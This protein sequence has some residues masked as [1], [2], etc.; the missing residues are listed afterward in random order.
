MTTTYEPRAVRRLTFHDSVADFRTGADTPVKYLER[1]LARIAER[2]PLVKAFVAANLDAA[3][4]RAEGATKRYRD[5]AP[6]SPVDG[7][8]IAVKDVFETRDLPTG[9]GSTALAKQPPRQDAAIVHALRKGG[10]V[11]VGKTALPELGF[12]PP[13]ATTNPWDPGRSPGGSSSGSAAAVAAAMVP[14]AIGSQGRGSLTRP[15]SFCGVTA[16]KPG[17]GT[18]HRGGYGGSQPT[19]A[20][21]GVLAGCL[22]DAWIIARAL[23]ESA[24]PHP[25]HAALKGPMEP[26]EPAKPRTLVRTEAAGWERTEPA[27]RAAYDDLLTRIE[28]A[29]VG[30]M[31][32]GDDPAWAALE[33]ELAAAGKALGT[34][35]D[36]ETRWPLTMLVEA[37]VESGGGAFDPLTVERGLERLAV[38]LADYEAAL[39]Y[40]R[41]YRERLAALA[42]DGVFM[43][44]PGATGPAPAGL[45]STGSSVYQWASSLAGNPV[46]SLPL[47]AADG[48]P[49]GLEVQG[50]V[51]Q[52]AALMAAG[53]WLARSFQAGEI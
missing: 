3:M 13:A 1:C 50:F 29:G 22:E 10:G 51:G 30:V 5:G 26:P 47:M 35:A 16:F 2:E 37:D 20:H 45:S 21:V 28:S 23:G 15:A 41:D 7:L 39:A 9:W 8:P 18:V 17:H 53:L 40:R 14:A 33:G 4:A 49:L 31:R 52:D 6:L 25:G 27:A 12:G 42:Q 38:P 19:N 11:L 44:T 34:I 24:G 46:V 43:I 36:Y 32:A 48:L